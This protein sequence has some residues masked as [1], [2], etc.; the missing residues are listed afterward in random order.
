VVLFSLF[1]FVALYHTCFLPH[2]THSL[3]ITIGFRDTYRPAMRRST[4][5]YNSALLS[6]ANICTT[7]IFIF[8]PSQAPHIS[9]HRYR[10]RTLAILV[11]PPHRYHE[12]TAD[13][14]NSCFVIGK[15]ICKSLWRIW[16]FAWL[17]GTTT[18][19]IH[20]LGM[21]FTTT[22]VFGVWNDKGWTC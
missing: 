11:P 12:P 10:K 4:L 19:C 1:K 15:N 20:L 7:Y 13:C 22:V 2:L 6:V 9:S 21:T 17:R 8:V 16:H 3:G 18:V 5:E 14:T